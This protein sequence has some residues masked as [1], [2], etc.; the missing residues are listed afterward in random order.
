MKDKEEYKKFLISDNFR[1]WKIYLHENQYFL[2]RCYIWA[3]RE[4]FVDFFDLTREE[5][6]E[7][8]LITKK[9]KEALS[10][11]FKPDLFNYAIFSNVAKHLHAHVIPRY[12]HPRNFYGFNFVDETFGKDLIPRP[13]SR[14]EEFK[15]KFTDENFGRNYAPYNRDFEVPEEILMKIKAAIKDKLKVQ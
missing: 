4:D 12:K 11:S 8:I 3:K 5:I 14:Q 2:G 1:H 10:K 15:V 13:I 7:F 6:E 9:L